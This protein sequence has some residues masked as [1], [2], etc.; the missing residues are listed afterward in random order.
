MRH[1]I[2]LHIWASFK[3]IVASSALFFT[4]ALS[5]ASAEVD[6]QVLPVPGQPRL[7]VSIKGPISSSDLDG[8]L[9]G[10]DIK[11]RPIVIVFVES[12][13][14]DWYSA[15]EIGRL[16]RGI[17]ASVL[18]TSGGCYSA[19]VLILAAGTQRMVAGPVGIHRPYSTDL[20]PKSYAQA[21]ERFRALEIAT[22][23]YLSEMNLP[24]SLFDAMVRVSPES[25]RVLR[26]V[27]LE[28][29]GLSQDD[30]VTQEIDDATEAR[31]LG[32]SK[33]EYLQR[34]ARREKICEPKD[35]GPDRLRETIESWM[36]CK[37]AV[38]QGLR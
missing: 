18:V 28:Q 20:S 29:F 2:D 10:I 8:L 38:M 23:S 22:K 3:R 25:I 12:R 35:L 9:R 14:G 5:P 11:R 6:V 30:P 19:C 27:E 32:V 31:K 33:Q 24:D 15:I 16:L 34:K 7:L 4:F 21:Q 37:K 1:A 13:G 17:E 26:V 36:S